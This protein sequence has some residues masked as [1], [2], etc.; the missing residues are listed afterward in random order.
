MSQIGASNQVDSY[1]SLSLSLS[2]YLDEYN[3]VFKLRRKSNKK[4]ICERVRVRENFVKSNTGVG[5]APT[6]THH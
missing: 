2:L 5:M 3:F 4:N 1:L 6:R